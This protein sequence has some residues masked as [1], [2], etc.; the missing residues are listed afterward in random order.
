VPDQRVDALNRLFK[1]DKTV[2]ARLEYLLPSGTKP[3]TPNGHGDES[4]WN[5]A[6]PC[7]ALI[8]VV[9]NFHQPGGEE[10]HPRDDFLKLETD[11]VFADLVVVEK[12][13]ERLDQ[14]KKRGKDINDEERQ[15]LE[16][17]LHMLEAQKPLRDDPQLATAHLLKGYAFL[18]A[19]PLFVLFNNDDEDVSLPTWE[20]PPELSNPLVIRGKLEME[21]SELSPE[22]AAEFFAAYQIKG[23]A[24]DRVIQRSCIVLG[25]ISFFTVIHN[26]VRSWMIPGG[27]S[28]LE[29]AEVVHSD[30]KKGFIRAEVIAYKDLVAAGSY[31]QAKKDGKVRLEGKTYI[32][33]DGDVITFHFNI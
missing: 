24:T 11:M 33:Q 29:A 9:R 21:L 15:L 3:Y 20:G 8:H 1:P 7:D 27:T 18:S 32:V 2:Y 12:R 10:P 16:A 17:C 19:K 25:L 22:E 30:M 28:A 23:F 14:D 6:R 26:E 31:Q 5:E 13:I 4:F